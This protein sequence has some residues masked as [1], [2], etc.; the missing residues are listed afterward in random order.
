M[1]ELPGLIPHWAR[2]LSLAAWVDLLRSASPHFNTISQTLSRCV[3][4][5]PQSCD[6]WRMMSCLFSERHDERFE[7]ETLAQR[8][9]HTHLSDLNNPPLAGFILS[10]YPDS[11]PL[12]PLLHLFSSRVLPHIHLCSPWTPQTSPDPGASLQEG[13]RCKW[14]SPFNTHTLL[15]NLSVSC[16]PHLLLSALV[17]RLQVVPETVILIDEASQSVVW[18]VDE[19]MTGVWH[20][21]RSRGA[22]SYRKYLNKDKLKQGRKV[23]HVE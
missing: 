1:S 2:F 4:G 7:S 23:G 14:C 12:A 20:V 8:G 22:S 5:P 17:Y 15:Q 21:D 16:Q 10:S 18:R 9:T 11:L 19:W 3:R 13:Q 6:I